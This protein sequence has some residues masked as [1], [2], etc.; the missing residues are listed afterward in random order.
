MCV[1]GG[2]FLEAFSQGD[3]LASLIDVAAER[4]DAFVSSSPVVSLICLLSAGR[5]KP[6]NYPPPAEISSH[7]INRKATIMVAPGHVIYLLA[8]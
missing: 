3:E 7:L 2:E 5:I 6:S 8:P 1:P 4:R